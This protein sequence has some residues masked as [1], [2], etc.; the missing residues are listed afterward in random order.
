MDGEVKQQR[1]QSILMFMFAQERTSARIEGRFKHFC[2][3]REHTMNY[4]TSNHLFVCNHALSFQHPAPASYR[5][6][7]MIQIRSGFHATAIAGHH[8]ETPIIYEMV[9]V[10]DLTLLIKQPTL[11]NIERL[12][13]VADFSSCGGG[14]GCE[15]FNYILWYIFSLAF[16][17]VISSVPLHG[18]L[19][20]TVRCAPA[21]QPPIS[22]VIQTEEW[23]CE[24]HSTSR[25]KCK[26]HIN[27]IMRICSTS[28]RSR[29]VCVF[30]CHQNIFTKRCKQRMYGQEPRRW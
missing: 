9:D 13:M 26:T 14:H 18:C 15:F 16:F 11:S 10:S 1:E 21:S 25:K 5:I 2:D 12:W 29:C 17:R 27:F 4:F 19:V 24:K 7:I 20:C 28:L 30:C 8:S 22:L 6:I 3:P 23:V